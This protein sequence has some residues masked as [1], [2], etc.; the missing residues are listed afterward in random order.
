MFS[1]GCLE[2]KMKNTIRNYRFY[3]KNGKVGH[4]RTNVVWNKKAIRDYNKLVA[5]FGGITKVELIKTKSKKK[6]K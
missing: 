3:F 4:L 5:G 2:I 6:K 1:L